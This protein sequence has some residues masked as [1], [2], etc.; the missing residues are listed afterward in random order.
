MVITV[1]K[2]FKKL[3]VFQYTVID[4]FNSLYIMSF[5]YLS[6]NSKPEKFP[7]SLEAIL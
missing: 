2:S 7:F 5:I 3:F 6:K 4:K 1:V